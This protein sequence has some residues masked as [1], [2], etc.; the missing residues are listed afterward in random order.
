ML[1]KC[2]ERSNS[3]HRSQIGAFTTFDRILD[4]PFLVPAGYVAETRLE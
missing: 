2:F 3:W 1:I 4:M